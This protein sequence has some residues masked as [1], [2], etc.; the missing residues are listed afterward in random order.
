MLKSKATRALGNDVK[1][2]VKVVCCNA[3]WPRDRLR[4]AGCDV[5]EGDELCGQPDSLHHRLWLCPA[6]AA[7]EARQAAADVY[8][9]CWKRHGASL[10]SLDL[11]RTARGHWREEMMSGK[12]TILKLAQDIAHSS[13]SGIEM[14]DFSEQPNLE[15]PVLEDC[16]SVSDFSWSTLVTL[17]IKNCKK[18]SGSIPAS[19]RACVKLRTLDLS[20]CGFSGAL[21]TRAERF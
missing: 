2:A 1:M 9:N 3:L 19:I 5:P 7:V 12:E 13:A 16:F 4:L 21:S 8:R 18:A 11:S 15:G 17:K 20:G 10:S 6:P 14:I